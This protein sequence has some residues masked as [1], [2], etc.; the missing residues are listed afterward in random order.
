MAK[1]AQLIISVTTE[2]ATKKAVKNN[3]T[4]QEEKKTQNKEEQGPNSDQH[5]YKWP[6]RKNQKLTNTRRKKK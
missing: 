3:T 6:K 2:E 5:Q 1:Y 4:K